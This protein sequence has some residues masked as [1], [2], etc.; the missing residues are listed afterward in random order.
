MRPAGVAE[1]PERAE[2]TSIVT[3]SSQSVAS[4]STGIRDRIA[5]DR[6]ILRVIYKDRRFIVNHRNDL[7]LAGGIAAVISRSPGARDGKVSGDSMLRRLRNSHSHK[8]LEHRLV[9]FPVQEGAGQGKT[10]QGPVRTSRN[11]IGGGG[12]TGVVIT[13]GSVIQRIISHEAG[14]A[15]RQT[16]V[17]V[18]LNFRLGTGH[19]PYPNVRHR[20]LIAYRKNAY[21]RPILCS[22]AMLIVPFEVAE[23]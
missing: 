19:I 16:L 6:Y 13:C 23:S 7:A 5:L 9:Q 8:E 4:H 17:H 3:L 12:H 2:V 20:T 11:K 21:P 18:R 22:R 15:S 10:D 1:Q 14:F